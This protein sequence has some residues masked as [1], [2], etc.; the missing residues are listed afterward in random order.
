MP[1]LLAAEPACN[2]VVPV[3]LCLEVGSLLLTQAHQAWSESSDR[4]VWA[5]F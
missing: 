4:I 3:G 2:R 1:F 5:V